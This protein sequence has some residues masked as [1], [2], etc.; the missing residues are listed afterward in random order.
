MQT[1]G[2]H[3]LRD[4]QNRVLHSGMVNKREGASQI[5]LGCHARQ[6]VNTLMMGHWKAKGT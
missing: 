6:H 3:R 2:F 4:I 5:V 1:I